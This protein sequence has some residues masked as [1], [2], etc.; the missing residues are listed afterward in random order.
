M[1]MNSFR[2]NKTEYIIDNTLDNNNFVGIKI[3]KGI[4]HLYFPIGYRVKEG[5]EKY[6]KKIL[7]YLYKTILLTKSNHFEKRSNA[8]Q[9][10]TT[11][12]IDSYLAILSDYYSN[13]IYNY[14]EVKYQKN[15]M[16]NIHWKKTFKN[17]FYIQENT[18]IYLDTIIRYNKKETN[19][20]TLLQLYAV[21]KSIEMLSYMGEYNK[22]YS[23]LSDKDIINNSNYYNNILDKE[24][25]NTNND[26]KKLLLLNIKSIIN[27]CS[28][29]DKTIRA[30]GTYNYEYSFEKMINKLFGSEED[31]SIYYPTALWFLDGDKDGFESSKLREDTIWKGNDKVYIIDSKYYR[32][33]IEREDSLL[34]KTSAIHKQIVYG[35]YVF[36]K[37]KKEK[38][39]V[40][41]I[42]NVFVIPSDRDEFLEYKGYTKM[43]LLDEDKDYK[44]VYLLFINMNEVV[45][46]YFKKDYN[47]IGKMINIIDNKKTL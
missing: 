40:Y 8:N 7:R 19:I 11:I 17:H 14:N 23:E 22:P 18:P 38:G 46:K 29:T 27:D 4:Y 45:D 34:P 26:K 44:Y 33:G 15:T 42:Y 32:Y 5:N 20:I 28:N 6:Y 3:I 31:L 1:K 36:N 9:E 16:G 13:G 35:D 39:K 47:Q 10:E 30:F 2:I 43:K 12:P 24:L 37:L 21:N 41:Q 25:K